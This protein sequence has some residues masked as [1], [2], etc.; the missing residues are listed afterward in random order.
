MK[1]EPIQKLID[2]SSLFTKSEKWQFILMTVFSSMTALLEICTAFSVALLARVLT[3]PNCLNEYLQKYLALRVH[4]EP[5]ETVLWV[6]SLCLGLYLI[7]S[8]FALTESFYQQRVIQ[9]TKTALSTR[10]LRLYTKA[11]YEYYLQQ[12]TSK[13]LTL[14]S[15]DLDRVFYAGIYGACVIFSELVVFIFL[16]S[17]LIF[18]NPVSSLITFCAGAVLIFFLIKVLLKRFYRWGKNVHESSQSADQHLIQFFHGFKEMILLNKSEPFIHQY[19]SFIDRAHFNR[20]RY[21][22]TNAIP[23]LSL[24]IFF[25]LIITILIGHLTLS[26][27]PSSE[28]IALLG[29]YLYIG[30]RII[31]GTNRI[32]THLNFFKAIQAHFEHVQKEHQKLITAPQMHEEPDLT[33]TQ[34]IQLDS[35]VYRYP[36]T[37]TIALNSI[38][39]TLK[40][41]ESIGII[42]ETGSGKST[43]TDLI[44]GLIQP[45][46]GSILADQKFA[47]NCPQW[48]SKIGYV[49]QALYLTDDTI[50]ANIAFGEPE[51]EIDLDRVQ[52]AAEYA[53]LTT[54]IQKLPDGFNTMVGDRGIRLS[55]GERQR[56][57]IARALYRNPEILIFDEATSALDN[58]TEKTLIETIRPLSQ[59]RTLIMVA[60]RLTTLRYCDRILVLK[61]GKIENIVTY[62]E[63]MK[64]H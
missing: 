20:A 64:T 5:Q 41:G 22:A 39:L 46:E 18:I 50:S 51:S 62:D 40:K 15:V 11:P 37:E 30:F 21:L 57:G 10:L 33:F 38:S 26:G 54:L 60:H 42:G 16:I 55:G 25:I 23:R 47:L 27:T 2:L 44:L 28:I 56:V 17:M 36:N 12:N 32:L 43:L 63:L 13:G 3:Q 35:V 61:H 53:Q 6:I 52:K 59:N 14:F 34:D 29:G 8:G 24:E 1:I 19:T 48:H 9:K 49:P 7:K 45:Q 31:P 58:E 4:I